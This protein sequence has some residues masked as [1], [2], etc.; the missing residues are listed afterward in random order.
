MVTKLPKIPMTVLSQSNSDIKP[1]TWE[2]RE[3]LQEE[4]AL[5]AR[6][7]LEKISYMAI[8][9]NDIGSALCKKAVL[10]A[11][12]DRK[13][14]DYIKGELKKSSGRPKKWDYEKYKDLLMHYA[15]AVDEYKKGSK[16]V[17]EY[18]IYHVS[19]INKIE[20]TE[21]AIE[22]LIFKAIKSVSKEN[23]SLD[24][25]HD[26]VRP[27]IQARIDKGKMTRKKS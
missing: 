22:N 8:G 20:L 18:L 16:Q 21:E 11:K 1:L 10:A 26:W 3:R 25:L 4:W 24:C 17:T 2:Q 23:P 13:L 7:A 27:V 12:C 15:Y 5:W 19:R 9:N 14:L 6:D